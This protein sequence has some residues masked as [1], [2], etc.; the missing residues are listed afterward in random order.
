MPDLAPSPIAAAEAWVGGSRSY[1]GGL[2]WSGLFMPGAPFDY[3]PASLASPVYGLEAA[4]DPVAVAGPCGYVYVGLRRLHPRRPEQAGSRPLPGPQQRRERRHLDLPGHD[5]G[6]D[7]QQ[8]DLRPLPRQ[9]A[10]RHR[11]RTHCFVEEE[12]RSFDAGRRTTSARTTSTSATAPS[13]ANRSPASSRAKST[14]RSRTT[15]AR[16]SPPARSTRTSARTRARSSPSTRARALPTPA[17]AARSTSSG[18]TSSSP[19]SII[20]TKSTDYGSSW[21]SPKRSSAP[22]RWPTSTNRPSP[23]ST[24]TRSLLTFRSNGFPTAAVTGDGTVFVAWQEKVNISRG[25]PASA[26]PT[27]PVRRA[28]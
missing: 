20:M 18:G 17:A 27:P 12:A 19:D 7:R 26:N 6:R 23:P 13:P 24:A 9:T 5:S 8:R 3:S 22:L 4:T 10:H 28:S 11:C 1:D 16:T 21:S 15:T 2:T 25:R 14:S